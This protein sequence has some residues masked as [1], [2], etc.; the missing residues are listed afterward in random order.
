[1]PTDK[2]VCIIIDEE[3]P[4]ILINMMTVKLNDIFD[5]IKAFL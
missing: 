4:E 2:T 3:N 1:M 5:K